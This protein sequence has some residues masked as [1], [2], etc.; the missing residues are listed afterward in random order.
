MNASARSAWHDDQDSRATIR[1]HDR[2]FRCEAVK[3]LPGEYYTT[4]EPLALVTVLG[5]CVSACLRDPVAGVGGMNHFML[6]FSELGERAGTS[7]RY[8]SF[9]M[10]ILVNDL[11]KQGARR[12]RLEAKIFGGGNVLRGFTVNHVGERNIAFVREYL[13]TEG[14][15]IVAEDVGVKHAR[16]LCYV[17]TSGKAFVRRI[18]GT[19][20]GAEL[21]SERAYGKRLSTAPVEG[22]VELFD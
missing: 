6:P 2:V 18:E 14:I 9:A 10:E 8:G 11:L 17:P 3:L 21:A 15:P 12:G 19:V 20:A 16:K 4:G 13:R 22:Q 7:A 1:Y 5:S